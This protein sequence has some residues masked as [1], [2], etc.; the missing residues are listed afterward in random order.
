MVRTRLTAVSP[1]PAPPSISMRPTFS[2]FDRC[3]YAEG[4]ESALLR[5]IDVR[6]RFSVAVARRIRSL[7]VGQYHP[8]VTGTTVEYRCSGPTESINFLF[9]STA[10]RRDINVYPVFDLFRFAHRLQRQNYVAATVDRYFDISLTLGIGPSI[11]LFYPQRAI[12]HIQMLYSQASGLS[13]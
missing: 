13:P 5:A 7:G 4:T 6:M 2:G 1:E 9:L 3:S 11:A 8:G 10:D 12:P